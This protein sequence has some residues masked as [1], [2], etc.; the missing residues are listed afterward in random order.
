MKAKPEMTFNQI[1]IV[2]A[3]IVLVCGFLFWNLIF[4]NMPGAGNTIFA[5]IMLA[6]IGRIST[7]FPLST[8][9][10]IVHMIQ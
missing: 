3:F 10:L 6:S 8:R 9:Q 2:F 1:D 4:V 7:L 5:V